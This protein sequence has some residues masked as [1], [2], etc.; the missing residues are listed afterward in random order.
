MIASK[1]VTSEKASAQ[2]AECAD[3]LSELSATDEAILTGGKGHGYGHGGGHGYGHGGGH[4]YGHGGH[5]GGHGGHGGGHGGHGGYY[6][7]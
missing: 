3:L 5:G 2:F 6:Y 7:C 1:K 4:G